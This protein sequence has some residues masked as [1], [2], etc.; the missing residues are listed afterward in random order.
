MHEPS[1]NRC[2]SQEL[3]GTLPVRFFGFPQYEII[4]SFIKESSIDILS[5]RTYTLEKAYHRT[6]TYLVAFRTCPKKLAQER[7]SLLNL[8]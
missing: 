7:K 2:L 1:R 8:K 3:R 4:C 5:I 6:I